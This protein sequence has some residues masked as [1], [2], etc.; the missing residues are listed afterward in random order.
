M[1]SGNVRKPGY[2]DNIEYYKCIIDVREYP[3]TIIKYQ[4]TSMD[5]P[6]NFRSGGGG[7]AQK[8]PPPWSK[9]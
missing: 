4:Y 9:K 7:Q 8:R 3:Q 1:A 6:R 5:A 2:T